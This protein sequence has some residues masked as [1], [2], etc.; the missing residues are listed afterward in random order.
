M[1]FVIYVTIRI[2]FSISLMKM[3]FIPL[4]FYYSH[5]IQFVNRQS[6]FAFKK[7]FRRTAFSHHLSIYRPAFEN[8]RVITLP[9][10]LIGLFGGLSGADHGF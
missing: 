7:R 5:F 1:R 4:D 2:A 10:I 6:N 8:A 9:V 3:R